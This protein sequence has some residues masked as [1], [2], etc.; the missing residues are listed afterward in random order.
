VNTTTAT[1]TR[2][3]QRREAPASSNLVAGAL[4]G[5]AG[6]VAMSLFE[7]AWTSLASPSRQSRRLQHAGGGLRHPAQAEPRSHE[8][9]LSTSEYLI[10]TVS[11]KLDRDPSQRQ[12][13]LLGSAF[14]YAFGAT[15]GTVYSAL[16]PR[17]PGLTAARGTLYGLLVWLVADELLVPAVRI[18]DPPWRT[19]LRLHLYS[20]GAHLAYG[21]GLDTTRRLIQQ[22][23]TQDKARG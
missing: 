13:E 3:A 19:P 21:L 16:A 1:P 2:P 5:V 10:E 11:Q 17:H 9:P 4:A 23:A 7:I 8:K 14:H 22:R 6:T 12:R 15:A 20:I 18:A